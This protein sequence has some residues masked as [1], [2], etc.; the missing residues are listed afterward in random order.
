MIAKI[1]VS[2]AN[3][4][5]DKPY[6]YLVPEG[7]TLMPGQRVQLPFGRGNT[8]TEGVVLSVE[9][10]SGEKLKWVERCLDEVP[11]LTEVQLR[12]AAFL[13]ERYFCTFYDAIRAMLPAGLWFQTKACYHLTEE[14]G[15]KDKPSRKEAAMKILNLMEDLGGGVEEPALRNLIEDEDILADAL[16][17]L[18]RKKWIRAENEFQQRTND[19]T[20]KIVTLVS[21]PEEAMEYASHRP[22]SAAMQKAVLELLC[23]L[24]SVAAKEL[25]YFTGAKMPTLHRLEALG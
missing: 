8:R 5:I 17:Y 18:V 13:R 24:D 19:K 16:S 1:A 12:L 21:S 4:A 11:V 15:W 14:R 6:S 2:A 7:M 20:E 25:C 3:F 10:G 9:E 23:S 22:R